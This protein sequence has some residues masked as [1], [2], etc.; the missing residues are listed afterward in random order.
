MNS[1]DCLNQVGGNNLLTPFAV[2]NLDRSDRFV[3]LDTVELDNFQAYA[4][5][6]NA[7]TAA[8]TGSSTYFPKTF[9]LSWN[10]EMP[11]E[12][13]ANNGNVTDISTNSFHILAATTSASANLQISY[14]SR[15]R[16]YG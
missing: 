15:C 8:F 4:F 3:I 6:D 7:G 12:F 16:F 14:V 2:A 1:E 13:T 10:G 11:V 9:K 5:N